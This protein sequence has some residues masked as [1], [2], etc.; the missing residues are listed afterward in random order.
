[1]KDGAARNDML[2]RL[3]ADP[4]FGVPMSDLEALADPSRFTGRAPQQVTEF[5]DEEVEPVLARYTGAAA[6]DEVRV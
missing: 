4:A 3:A 2:D 1:V 5:L 6:T